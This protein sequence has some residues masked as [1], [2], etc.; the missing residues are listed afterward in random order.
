MFQDKK[1]AAETKLSE[2]EK[3]LEEKTAGF[4]ESIAKTNTEKITKEILEGLS[5]DTD[6]SDI[7]DAESGGEDSEDR[8]WR[9]SHAVFGKST[10]KQ[11][12]LDNMRGR[13]FRDM[14]IVRADVDRAVPAPEENKVVI[15]WSFFK[16]GLRFPLSRFVVEVLKT[17]QIFLHQI[18]PEAI[19][20]MGIFVWAVRSQGLE[21]SARC[22]CSMHE[23]SYET[24]PWGK[25]QYHNNFGCYSFVARSGS[26]YPVPTF[27]KRWPG[28]WMEEWFYVKNDLKA[29]EDIKEIIMRPI[30]S[31]FGLRKP[32][33]EINEAAKACRRAFSTICSFIGT[34]DIVQEH[35]AYR[36]W[37][38][39][40]SWEMPKGTITNPSE[41]GLV[42][43][44]YTF[45]FGDRFVEPDD[46]WLKCVEN[47]SDELLE[48]Y[49]KSEDN[50]LSAAF[51][52]RKKKRLNRVFDAIGFVYP[53]YRYPPR[54][55]KR[56]GAASGKVAISAAPSEPVPKR[57]KLKVLTHR[58]RYIEPAIVPV[59]GGETSAVTEAKEP[60]PPTQ[61]IEE[62]AVMPKAP[63]SKLIGTRVIED[64]AEKSK[65]EG[66]TK[67]PEILSPSAET[68]VLKAE[69]SSAITPRKKRMVNVLDILETTDSKRPSSIKK[70]AENAEA[71][72]EADTRQIKDKTAAIEARTEAEPIV[73]VEMKLATEG[74]KYL[75]ILI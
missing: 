61:K 8:P 71:Q 11:S 55:Q 3:L 21:P 66:A 39:I 2:E 12:H 50:A 72:T 43:L 16:A 37:P 56:K 46:D 59:F 75:E 19:I 44:K 57:K 45:R 42:R 32:K 74:K 41:G 13:Y 62:P 48:A 20:R 70:V 52:S 63:S 23:L 5:E 65:T 33:I 73:P 35:V 49:S 22:F 7:Y 24:K 54:G 53:D 31:R 30:W 47:T 26:S 17:Y 34:R 1:V 18:T 29:R 10:I 28:A 67:M 25:E 40:D 64:K 4:V 51:G 27:Q 68:T 14:S 60:A 6:D 15:F 69:K 9:P 38:L 58:L 36:I